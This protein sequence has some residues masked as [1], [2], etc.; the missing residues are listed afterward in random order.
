MVPSWGGSAPRGHWAMSGDVCG[1]HTGGAAGIKWVGGGAAAQGS[2][3]PRRPRCPQGE[4]QQE[5]AWKTSPALTLT[6]E[7]CSPACP[8]ANLLLQSFSRVSSRPSVPCTG[9]IPTSLAPEKSSLHL[10]SSWNTHVW[11]PI[12]RDPD[13]REPGQGQNGPGCPVCTPPRACTQAS[14]SHGAAGAW[15]TF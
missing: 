15:H 7:A 14:H 2:Q 5:T 12:P 10:R 11:A 9:I 6:Q 3:C 4:T 1:H 13:S 8:L